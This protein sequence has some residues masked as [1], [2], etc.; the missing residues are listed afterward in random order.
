MSSAPGMRGDAR[1]GAVHR[2]RGA[3]PDRRS[4][5]GGG[6]ERDRDHLRLPRLR[7]APVQPAAGDAAAGHPRAARGSD[8]TAR[9]AACSSRSRNR[10]ARAPAAR[11]CSSRLS[12]LLF[13]EVVRRHL[14]TCRRPAR[15]ARRACATSRS[16]ACSASC[17]T[18][19]PPWS[20]DE[21][22]REVGVSRSVLAERFAQFVGVPP[23]QYLAQWRMQLAATSAVATAHGLGRDRR[24]RSATARRRRSAAPSSG[25]WASRPRSG[26]R[27][28]AG[29][30][31]QL[32]VTRAVWP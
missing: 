5:D 31:V 3:A 17:T 12:E 7:R 22:A 29:R 11:A 1:P 21:L 28:S 24:A 30:E 14:A 27:V 25:W 9:R 19:G 23:M 18:P 4:R 13:V 16:G 2:H 32:A 8:E 15:L 26:V 20:L 10:G 6:S